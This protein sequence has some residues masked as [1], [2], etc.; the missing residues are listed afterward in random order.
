MKLTR[1]EFQRSKEQPPLE[2]FR[3]GIRSKET[4]EKYERTLRWLLTNFLEEFL[5]GSFEER[6]TY[7]VKTAREDP[8]LI[9]DILLNISRKLRERTELAKEDKNYLNPSSFDNYF[10][11]IKKLFDMTDI[12]M[13]WR[14]IYSTFP[15]LENLSDGRGWTR[16][17]IQ[18]ML[19]FARGAIDRAIILVASSSCM[20]IG[21]FR[22][23]WDD[24]V[25]I[26][27]VGE[28]L[29]S[30]LIES[31]T[32]AILVCAAIRIY[33][34]ATE[35]YPA[36]ITP[37]AYQALQEYKK[38]WIH[39][40]G[41][42]PKPEE[43]MF[44]REGDLPIMA[45]HSSIKK[46]VERMIE[47]AGLRKRLKKGQRRHE[48][49]IMNGFRRFW[50]K[51]C[52]ESLSR[53]S[54]VGSLIKKE[55]MMGHS[56]LFKLDRNYFKTHMLE[57]AEEYLNS[58]PALT[59]SNEKRLL[60][61]NIRLRKDNDAIRKMRAEME[62]FKETMVTVA[63][64]SCITSLDDPERRSEAIRKLKE[65]HNVDKNKPTTVMI[66]INKD[67]LRGFPGLTEIAEEFDK[68]LG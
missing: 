13:P 49:P 54:P 41:R 14:K 47:K 2:L 24:L 8:S 57:L 7:L 16:Q 32:N 66:N 45:T 25:P 59:I 53:D 23:H 58:V 15:A 27:K 4:K 63:E 39:Q 62:D 3:Q 48:V 36:F 26:Y 5:E 40:V 65:K 60:V 67:Y 64:L 55:Y 38:E 17:E 6:V 34:G 28:E 31:Y 21:G 29:R 43:P 11:P 19:N 68:N 46:R 22:L 61:D 42:E 52:K 12:S 44:K 33:K 9:V 20:R 1:D 51:T 50:N 30:E 18:E 37:E 35:Q 56:G 10:K